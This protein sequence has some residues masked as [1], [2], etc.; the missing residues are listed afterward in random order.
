MDG[1]SRGSL[2][3]RVFDL[4]LFSLGAEEENCAVYCISH[5]Y[6]VYHSRNDAKFI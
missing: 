5:K 3:L 2:T 6:S 4:Q 1:E